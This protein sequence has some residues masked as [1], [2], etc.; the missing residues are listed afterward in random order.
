[1]QNVSNMSQLEKKQHAANLRDTR[2]IY[3]LNGIACTYARF[4]LVRLSN[5]G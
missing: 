4:T 1:M 2:Y 3:D 5:N